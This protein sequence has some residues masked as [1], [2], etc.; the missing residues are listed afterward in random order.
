GKA[1]IQI[2]LPNSDNRQQYPCLLQISHNYAGFLYNKCLPEKFYGTCAFDLLSTS[3]IYRVDEPSVL[4]V[5]SPGDGPF[6]QPVKNGQKQWVSL[7]SRSH[8][9]QSL[10]VR[11]RD[12]PW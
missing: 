10:P 11:N 4:A 1:T 12:M 6:Q 7:S 2:V 8:Q 5:T 3:K 9:T